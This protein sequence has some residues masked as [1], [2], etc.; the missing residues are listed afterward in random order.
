MPLETPETPAD[1]APPRWVDRHRSLAA[2]LVVMFSMFSPAVDLRPK[3][4]PQVQHEMAEPSDPPDLDLNQVKD[5]S[6][7]PGGLL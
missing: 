1:P 6:I 7:P 5:G 3:P 2:A 4:L